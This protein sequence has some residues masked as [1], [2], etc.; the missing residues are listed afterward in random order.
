[1]GKLRTNKSKSIWPEVTPV[2]ICSKCHQIIK[3]NGNRY[4]KVLCPNPHCRQKIDYG[5]ENNE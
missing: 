2:R 1:M 4:Q 3:S 5:G